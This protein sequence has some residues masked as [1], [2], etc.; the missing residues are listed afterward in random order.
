MLVLNGGKINKKI[1]T[2]RMVPL[3]LDMWTSR[4]NNEASADVFHILFLL[5]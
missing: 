2:P 5:R 3:P 1:Q 4:C